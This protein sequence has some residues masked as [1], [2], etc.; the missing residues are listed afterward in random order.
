MDLNVVTIM[1]RLTRDAELKSTAGGTAVCKFG[2]TVNR[3]AK[4]GD[5]WESNPWVFV[6]EIMRVG[7]G[8]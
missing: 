3:R 7:A 4:K 1:G 6:Y 8:N 2:I 5:E